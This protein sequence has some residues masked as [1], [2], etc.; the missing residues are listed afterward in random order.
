MKY[1]MWDN[2]PILYFTKG[3]IKSK[4]CE[5]HVD[6]YVNEKCVFRIIK[7]SG[8]LDNVRGYRCPIAIV[9]NSINSEE[10]EYAIKPRSGYIF[11]HKYQDMD[12]KIDDDWCPIMEV[13]DEL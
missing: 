8:N 12:R 4:S 1:S 5:S 7:T 6:I 2:F 9:D 11:E 10:F 3:R 13:K